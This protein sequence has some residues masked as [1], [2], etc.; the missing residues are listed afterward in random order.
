MKTNSAFDSPKLNKDD[1]LEIKVIP[2]P[3]SF[4]KSRN[5]E[6]NI[7]II[8][9]VNLMGGIGECAENNYKRAIEL[10]KNEGNVLKIITDELSE[11][12]Q[13]KYFDRWSL[14]YLLSEIKSHT[15]LNYLATLIASQIPP[16]RSPKAHGLSTVGEEIIIRTTAVEGVLRLASDGNKD[17]LEIL[18]KNISNKNFSIKRACIQ[19][20][21]EIDKENGK[22]NIL[23][24]LPKEEHFILGITRKH[25]SEV[26]P[27]QG[28]LHLK[29]RSK[30]HL[31]PLYQPDKEKP[32]S[33]SDEGCGC[34]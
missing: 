15:S 7:R 13:D 28:E 20:I 4:K 21:L 22:K 17:A 12:P 26:H 6:L 9:A 34:K 14:V 33:G 27:I 2:H 16:E 24:R 31:P 18:Y 5:K 30:D 8:E 32:E 25:P 11:M 10:L 23:E 3:F 29:S 1:N 19:G